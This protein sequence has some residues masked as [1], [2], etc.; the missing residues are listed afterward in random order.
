V[1]VVRSMFQLSCS[2]LDHTHAQPIHLISLF[3]R[4]CSLSS[5]YHWLPHTTGIL[6]NHS[7]AYFARHPS[8]HASCIIAQRPVACDDSN[9]PRHTLSYSFLSSSCPIAIC[10]VCI[11]KSLR[12]VVQ[13]A[14][15]PFSQ[16]TQHSLL[17]L[18][19]ITPNPGNGSSTFLTKAQIREF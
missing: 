10:I 2:L 13:G 19:G 5:R 12:A 8:H 16:R 17:Q 1:D 9:R 18:L 3:C 6:Y 7:R 4:S 14:N 11:M 15:P